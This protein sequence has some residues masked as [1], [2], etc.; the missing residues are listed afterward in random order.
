MKL[1][2]CLTGYRT[3]VQ[4]D[5]ETVGLRLK[6]GLKVSDAPINPMREPRLLVRCQ[7]AEAGDDPFHDDETMAGRNW[8]LVSGDRKQFVL[9]QDALALNVA[10]RFHSAVQF[11]SFQPD[12]KPWFIA[13]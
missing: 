7:F 11:R 12:W 13:I 5:I 10:K 4:A 8:I 6:R 2:D 9:R 3:V 1:A